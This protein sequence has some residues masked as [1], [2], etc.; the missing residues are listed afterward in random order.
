MSIVIT[1][2]TGLLVLVFLAAG[3][4]KVLLVRAVASN[5]RRLGADRG[6]ACLIGG[7]EILGAIG[8]AVG[9]W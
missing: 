3:L 6:L 8:L 4:Q 2:L 1:V 7:L 9:T 5:M